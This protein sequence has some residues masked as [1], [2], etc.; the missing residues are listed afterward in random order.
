ML[1]IIITINIIYPACMYAPR[2]ILLIAVDYRMLIVL[3]ELVFSQFLF[4]ISFYYSTMVKSLAF[5]RFYRAPVASARKQMCSDV[6]WTVV[7]V[8]VAYV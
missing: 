3:S 4:F 1:V 6:T 7:A 5:A 2:P 8:A